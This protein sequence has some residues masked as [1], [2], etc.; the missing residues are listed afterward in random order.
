M[1]P[2]FGPTT[3]ILIW[4]LL[5]ISC[6][7]VVS[8]IG[9]PSAVLDRRQISSPPERDENGYALSSFIGVTLVIL[10]AK[11]TLIHYYG[12]DLPFWD[13]W[14][15]E[16]QLL[17]I[18]YDQGKLLWSTLFASHNEHR[19]FFSRLWALS[20]Y[21][22]NQQWDAYLQTVANAFLHTFFGLW[23]VWILWKLNDKR[24]LW[25]IMGVFVLI[26]AVPFSWENTL[27][28]FQS[29]FYFL[30]GFSSLAILLIPQSRPFSFAW[31]IGIFFAVL[32]LFTM[33]AGFFAVLVSLAL[34]IIQIYRERQMTW[35]DGITVVFC[36]FIL[37]A[38]ILLMHV[39]EGHA[40]L[41]P[42]T[43]PA[44]MTA[45]GRNLSWPWVDVP[46]L[47]P[48][49]W[50]P[51]V[52]LSYRICIGNRGE[53][54][55]YPYFVMGLGLWTLLQ[56]IAMAYSRGFE[57]SGP[58]S[59]Y[60]DSLSLIPVV[61]ILAAHYLYSHSSVGL[62]RRKGFIIACSFWYAFS[63][64]GFL[65]LMI[66]ESIGGFSGMGSSLA[67]QSETIRRYL[68][69]GDDNVILKAGYMEIPYPDAQRLTSL[70]L[71]DA[72]RKILPVSVRKPLAIIPSVNLQ[73]DFVENGFF[74]TLPV[75]KDRKVWGSFGSSKG[76]LT[77]GYFRSEKMIPPRLP[78][79]RFQVSGYLDNSR[80]KLELY[81]M[82]DRL[83]T[84][85]VPNRLPKESWRTVD[86][87]SPQVPFYVKATDQARNRGG[88][89]A[90][91]EPAEIGFL[92]RLSEPIR[93]AGRALLVVGLTFVLIMLIY[94]HLQK[95]A[96][97][98]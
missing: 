88:W 18:P 55:R 46:V 22:I 67:K 7:A 51:F 20:L 83:I 96:E 72:I 5:V 74:S 28:G 17:Y 60:M 11:F 82:D 29:S 65:N 13:Q 85:V 21:A 73:N 44:F 41:R 94:V 70:L 9:N 58:A 81:S 1:I 4:T 68:A 15:T 48:L 80:L 59:R 63:V 12:S 89:F 8:C 86:V 37:L 52:I 19:V 36:L 34:M 42:K 16:P 10:G 27:F 66:N 54:P 2:Y 98:S 95:Q 35:R 14:D 84:A 64:I 3:L 97:S 78:Y 50:S 71:D 53:L 33:G 45:L 69:S 91:S 76:D 75:I 49:L 39:P 6:L 32:S 93:S 30:L 24:D 62:K 43:F 87:K 38:G 79:L 47:F 90:F 31:M 40:G 57:G 61:N 26:L 92:S 56:C 23:L 25:I 77:T